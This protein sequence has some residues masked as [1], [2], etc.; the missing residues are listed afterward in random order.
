MYLN[1][2]S[3][4]P[5]PTLLPQLARARAASRLHGY[6]I[7]ANPFSALLLVS[8]SSVQTLARP[9]RGRVTGREHIPRSRF[10]YPHFEAADGKKVWEGHMWTTSHFL[11]G[12]TTL[13]SLKCQVLPSVVDCEAAVGAAKH[14]SAQVLWAEKH[15]RIVLCIFCTAASKH[16]ASLKHVAACTQ[17]FCFKKVCE[18]TWMYLCE[19]AHYLAGWLAVMISFTRQHM[20]LCQF[21][22]LSALPGPRRPARSS[23]W[24]YTRLLSCYRPYCVLKDLRNSRHLIFLMFIS[25]VKS[26]CELFVSTAHHCPVLSCRLISIAVIKD[27]CYYVTL[28]ALK[29]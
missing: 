24:F 11:L 16:V 22:D 13:C 5:S 29:T 26:F 28:L 1:R 23:Y 14:E 20:F 6:I 9:S 19:G 3:P 4:L 7:N 27:Y 8:R 12:T 15:S 21:K 18:P 25:S 17:S 2:S 10:T